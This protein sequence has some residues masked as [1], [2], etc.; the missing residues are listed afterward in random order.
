[1]SNPAPTRRWSPVLDA[2]SFPA[3]RLDALA[4]RIGRLVGA[5][6]QDTVIV[7]GEAIVALEAVALELGHKRQRVLNLATS[8]YGLLFDEWLRRN[9]ASVT[10]IEPTRRGGAIDPAVVEAALRDGDFTALSLVHGEGATGIVNPLKRLLAIASA[11]GVVTLVDAVASVGAEPIDVTALG[12][13]IVVVGP[14]KGWAG[15]SGVS[16]VV[17][18]ER[19]WAALE[20]PAGATSLSSVSLLDLR[21][22]WIDTDRT[23]IPGTP[24][25][26][27]LW[28]LDEAVS[29]VEA[30]GPD[31]LVT[32][33]RTAAGATWQAIRA[34]GLEPWAADVASASGLVTGLLLPDGVDRAAILTATARYGA[35]L[36]AGVGPVP[37]NHVRL[38]HT[39]ARA[40]FGPIVADLAALASALTAAGVRVDIAASIAALS[41][42]DWSH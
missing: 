32:R 28:A 22:D 10:T 15:P 9:G 31:A 14:Q 30:E 37:A 26:L 34:L 16:A 6:G 21:R 40:A 2:P 20:R 29:R 12:A 23:V 27:E 3:S 1:M 39:G 5:D 13:D 17:I 8:H 24:L 25:T 4:T 41:E 42:A 35:A 36:T 11:S 18:G 38:N 33:H 7:P 19:G